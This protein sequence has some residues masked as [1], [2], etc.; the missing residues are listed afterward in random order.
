MRRSSLV[1]RIVTGPSGAASGCQAMSPVLGNAAAGV[2]LASTGATSPGCATVLGNSFSSE[3]MTV[4]PVFVSPIQQLRELV[5]HAH[6]TVG[7]RV[8]RQPARMQCDA[9]PG[10]SLHVGH[11][12]IVVEIR[13]MILVLL[14]DREDAGRRFV[15]L[16][17]GRDRG[18][19]DDHAVP[20]HVGELLRQRHDQHDRALR[21]KFGVPGVFARL[22]LRRQDRLRGAH[23]GGVLGRRLA[24]RCRGGC[25]EQQGDSRC[26]QQRIYSCVRTPVD[27]MTRGP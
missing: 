24:G 14:Q 1:M 25:Q 21:R 18:R 26:G 7:R 5:G 23:R 22:Q 10:E 4:S 6:A 16:L 27:P 2:P 9:R 19:A 13:V 3:T 12:R 17:S 8:A 15:A 11:G 20:V